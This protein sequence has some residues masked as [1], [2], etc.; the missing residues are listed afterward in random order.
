MII[1]YDLYLENESYKK[2][3]LLINS[4]NE[5]YS[6]DKIKSIW[7]KI[8]NKIS[9][10]SFENKKKIIRSFLIS[11]IAISPISSVIKVTSNSFKDPQIVEIIEDQIKF[12]D[13]TKMKLSQSGRDMIKEH[14][15]FRLKA[16]KIGDGMI[17]VGWGH[18]EPLDNSK[19]KDG[20]EITLKEAND[21]LSKDL[22]IAADG[23]RRIFNNW[24]ESGNY[25][26]ISQDMFDSLVSLAYNNG[27]GGL[28]KSKIIKQLKEKNYEEA[29]NLIQNFNVS[30]RVKDKVK[31]MKGLV[32]RREKESKLFLSFLEV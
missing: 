20:Q 32:I 6:L 2:C 23:V 31:K 10:L 18:A 12:F 9:N 13:A 3:E 29:G 21:L 17:T 16:Y 27:V 8:V 11:A 7:D 19:Y 1:S 15:G 14:E 24:K 26:P 4:I 28:K 25:V 22:T 30:V 5:G